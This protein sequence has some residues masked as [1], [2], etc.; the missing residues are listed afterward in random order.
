MING[1]G[2]GN[3]VTLLMS[4]TTFLLLSCFQFFNGH[5]QFFEGRFQ[6]FELNGISLFGMIVKNAPVS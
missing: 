5:F 1:L 3:S 2:E 6:F 4:L